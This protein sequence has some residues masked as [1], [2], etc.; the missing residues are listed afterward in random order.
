MWPFLTPYDYAW[1]TG[2][3]EVIHLDEKRPTRGC[4]APKARVRHTSTRSRLFAQ[5]DFRREMR[6]IA[7][8]DPGAFLSQLVSPGSFRDTVEPAR[9]IRPPELVFFSFTTLTTAGYG[10]IVRVM[11]WQSR[12]PCWNR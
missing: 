10:D 4:G 7:F 5:V 9:E 11:A 8:V 12:S 1:I 6:P 3:S 2:N